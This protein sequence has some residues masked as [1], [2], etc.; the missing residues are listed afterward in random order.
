MKTI[1]YQD[2]SIK[3]KHQIVNVL[4]QDENLTDFIPNEILLGKRKPPVDY[5]LG[6]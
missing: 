6:V 5:I 2:I 1:K 4:F 3:I